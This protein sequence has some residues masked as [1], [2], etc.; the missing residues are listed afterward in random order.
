MP[1]ATPVLDTLIDINTT[2]IEHS[3]LMPRELML[4]RIAALVAVDAP[5]ASYLAN[6]G[7][8]ADSGITE[9]D[10]Q[11]VLIAVA[12]VVGTAKVVSAGGNVMR[13]LGFA[14]TVAEADLGT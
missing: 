3:H 5:P 1:A 13:A 12:P 4:A 2:S 8:A 14:I 10:V 6:A 7:A 9:Q 11:D